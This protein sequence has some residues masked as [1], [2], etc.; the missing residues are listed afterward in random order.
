MT[1]DQ[2]KSSAS[3]QLEE[4]QYANGNGSGADSEKTIS[5]QDAERADTVKKDQVDAPPNGGYGWVCVACVFWINAHTWGINSV[6]YLIVF[7]SF[8]ISADRFLV[9]WC[10]PR[11]LSRPQYLSRRYPVGFCLHWRPVYISGADH[12][13]SCNECYS[14]V[15]YKDYTSRWRF[16]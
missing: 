3:P 12:L 8:T 1:A 7:P 4:P 11:L 13:T 6:R 9:I 14:F 5:P 15:W 10:F 2:P 16:P